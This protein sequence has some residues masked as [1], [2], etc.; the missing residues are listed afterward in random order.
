MTSEFKGLEKIDSGRKCPNCGR[1][2]YEQRA[3]GNIVIPMMC[4]C[5]LAK[6]KAE[7]E[8]FEKRK[9][10]RKIELLRQ[11]SGLPKKQ[12]GQNFENFQVRKGT[13]SA[14]KAAKIFVDK[15]PNIVHGLLLIGPCGSG[16]THIAAAIANEI[17]NKGYSVK[18]ITA[19]EIFEQTR[20]SY[21]ISGV[22]EASI[23]NP[24]KTCKLLIIDD[25][26]VSSPTE[27]NKSLLQSII[28]YRMNY[29]NPT[30]LTTNLNMSEL[31]ERLDPRTYDRLSEGFRTFSVIAESFRKRE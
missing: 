27:W 20:S 7:R 29:E 26:G 30:V 19:L 4:E 17:L 25:I 24:I 1:H 10:E 28:D 13:E 6:R 22:S 12:L 14:L 3:Y 16:K 8:A 18:F 23:I 2:L 9:R 31:K 15:F 21:G 11:N 5:E